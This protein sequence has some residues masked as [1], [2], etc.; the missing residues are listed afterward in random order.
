MNRRAFLVAGLASALAASTSLTPVRAMAR[1]SVIYIGGVD[2]DPCTRW[3]KAHRDTWM[4]SPEQKKV[5]W[6]EIDPP[7]LLMAYLPSYWPDE[8][9]PVLEQLPRKV[10][11]PRFLIV[12]DGRV[13]DNQFGGNAWPVT[14][15]NVRKHIG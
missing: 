13:V 10:G 6:I 5:R 4:A 2:C 8:L 1:V 14:V 12:V 11:T 9:R 7:S 15:G 3:K